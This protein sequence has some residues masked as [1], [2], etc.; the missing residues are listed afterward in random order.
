MVVEQRDLIFFLPGSTPH[1]PNEHICLKWFQINISLSLS[2]AFNCGLKF[3]YQLCYLKMWQWPRLVPRVSRSTIVSLLSCLK[4]SRR[5]ALFFHINKEPLPHFLR[6]IPACQS[7]SPDFSSYAWEPQ[8]KKETLRFF[9]VPW[10]CSWFFFFF[11]EGVEWEDSYP[12]I[13]QTFNRLQ[14]PP[15]KKSSFL[16]LVSSSLYSSVAPCQKRLLLVCAPEQ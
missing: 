1:L 9:L 11:V 5:V 13:S 10:I 15:K 3:I 16:W 7:F 4:V 14:S 8:L 12:F 6:L 2:C